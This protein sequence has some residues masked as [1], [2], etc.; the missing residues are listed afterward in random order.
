M[1]PRQIEEGQPAT[2]RPGIVY[3]QH[4]VPGHRVFS[5]GRPWFTYIDNRS[6]FPLGPFQPLNWSAPWY[7][8]QGAQVFKSDP[9][10]PTRISINYDQIMADDEAAMKEVEDSRK[11]AS[12]ARGWDPDDPSKQDMLDKIAQ[13]RHKTRAPQLAFAAKMG[14]PWILGV[15]DKVN[16]KLQALLPKKAATDSVRMSKYADV[17]DET[18]TTEP[19]SLA[20][21]LEGLM[22]IEES[23]DPDATPRGRV[24]V[25]PKKPKAAA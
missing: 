13:P 4:K 12:A 25:K 6:G 23:V 19:E 21:D 18:I 15:S 22:D 20:D 24:P 5:E 8:P 9:S 17:L 10:N 7:P 11:A 16:A 2:R 3:D 1:S 14:D